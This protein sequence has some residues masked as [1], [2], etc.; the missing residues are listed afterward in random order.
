VI[1]GCQLRHIS[2]YVRTEETDFHGTHFSQ[3]L[4]MEFLQ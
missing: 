2:L 1:N 3:N 4:S